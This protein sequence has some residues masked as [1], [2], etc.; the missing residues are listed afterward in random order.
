MH[1]L[2]ATLTTRDCVQ[3]WHECWSNVFVICPFP[4]ASLIQIVEKGCKSSVL[5]RQEKYMI[6]L[7]LCRNEAQ[8]RD[9]T[10]GADTRLGSFLDQ[11]RQFK[12]TGAKAT[13][14]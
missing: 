3:E 4:K 10:I 5:L 6:F 12:Y 7:Q 13:S 11:A 2:L 8:I 14:G 9:Q 1:N